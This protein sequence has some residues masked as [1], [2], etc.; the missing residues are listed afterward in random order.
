M[1]KTIIFGIIVLSLLVINGCEKKDVIPLD[2]TNERYTPCIQLSDFGS[3]EY[4]HLPKNITIDDNITIEFNETDI[5]KMNIFNLSNRVESMSNDVITFTIF[6]D[7]TRYKIS[8]P[9]LW[10]SCDISTI[11]RLIE[12]DAEDILY[13][14]CVDLPIIQRVVIEAEFE[15]EE[16]KVIVCEE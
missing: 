10:T 3:Y 14:I 2:I 9:D 13:D 1:K 4:S 16:H 11:E 7:N 12:L 6:D 5:D 15:D 8:S